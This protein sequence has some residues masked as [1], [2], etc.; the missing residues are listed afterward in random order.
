M[1]NFQRGLNKDDIQLA[2]EH[3]VLMLPLL[4]GADIRRPPFGLAPIRET[5]TPKEKE[6]NYRA[7]LLGV[8][9]ASWLWPASF[10][11]AA[12]SGRPARASYSGEPLYRAYDGNGVELH[13]DW[14]KQNEYFTA[15]PVVLIEHLDLQ[16]GDVVIFG[17]HSLIATG[18][19][20]EVSHM[21]WN[22]RQQ[23]Y[24]WYHN[25]RT[26]PKATV[27]HD[28]A[29][30]RD[31]LNALVA[32]WREYKEHVVFWKKPTRYRLR[33]EYSKL[34]DFDYFKA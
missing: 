2:G 31:S 20:D 34:G 1:S 5:A 25:G 21:W 12:G 17:G 23:R 10:F 16:L 4:L 33:D 30:T 14:Y 3:P 22:R 13:V 19:D 11:K 27:D 29:V 15:T 26:E 6:D 32:R 28:Y 9:R 18:R 24:M 7:Y 8:P